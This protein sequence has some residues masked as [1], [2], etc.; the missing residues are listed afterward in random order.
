MTE[1]RKQLKQTSVLFIAVVAGMALF[2]LIAVVVNQANGPIAPSLNAS[3][4]IISAALITIAFTCSL[5]A[6]YLFAKGIRDAKNSLNL[7]PAKLNRHRISLITYLAFA[8]LPVMLSVISF[9]LTGNFVY[10][11]YACVFL[12]FIIVMFPSRK[13][14]IEQLGLDG[15]E[16]LELE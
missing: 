12:G 8:E 3:R 7:L 14:V 4:T 6:K 15:Q 2:M 11:I 13:R 9:L 10:E 1:A 16:Q 5:L